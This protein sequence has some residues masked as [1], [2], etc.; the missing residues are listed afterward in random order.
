MNEEYYYREEEKKIKALYGDI[1]YMP[2]HVSSWHPLM[3]R[4]ER[5]SQ[6]GAFAALTGYHDALIEKARIVDDLPASDIL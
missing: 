1:L 3:S 4:S 5:A 2:H 6:F